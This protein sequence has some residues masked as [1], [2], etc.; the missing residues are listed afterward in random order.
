MIVETKGRHLMTAFWGGYIALFNNRA[1][2]EHY[3]LRDCSGKIPC[4]SIGCGDITIL[5][6]NIEDLSGLPLPRFSINTRYL[7][8]FV[9]EAELAQRECALNEVTELL[10]GERLEL[11]G[12]STKRFAAWDPRT[13]SREP[14][15]EDFEAASRQVRTVTQACVDFWASKYDRILHLL[16][17]GLDSSVILGCLK[18]SPDS[19]LVTCM[20]IESDG[21][22]ESESQYARLAASAAGVELK[23][24][25]GYSR[26]L[27]YD[28]RIFRVPRTPKPSVANLGMGVESALRNLIPSQTRAEAIWDGQGGDHL[29]FEPRCAFGAIDYAFRHGLRGDFS[30]HAV[31]AVHHSGLSYWGVLWRSIRLGLLH[32]GWRPA[33]EHPREGTF[34][35]PDIVP[36]EIS[37]YVW[38]PWL[39]DASDLPPG[40]RWQICLLGR[41][42][43]RHRPVPELQYSSEHHPLFSQPLFELCLRIPLYILLRGGSDR[44]LERTAFRDCVPAE[45]IRRQNKGSVSTSLMSTIR[46]SLPFLRALLL[47]GVLAKQRIIDRAALEPFLAANRPVQPKLLWPFLSCIAAETWARKWAA[48][49]WQL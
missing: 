38:Q 5:T 2:T 13:I 18:R 48:A 3:V 49:E 8:G 4:Y 36:P 17:G 6:S 9:Y 12:G 16:S 7:A 40:K 39:A 25:P 32:A 15:V 46:E 47:D 35:N 19:P 42:V 44:A 31:D 14:A 28:E 37:D 33:D 41:L 21:E 24:Q 27:K 43:H 1:G 30:K 26:L 22:G 34:L 20:H 29:F 11:T 10:A 23:F 45:I